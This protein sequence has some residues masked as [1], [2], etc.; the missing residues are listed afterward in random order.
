MAPLARARR[1]L[2]DEGTRA[3]LGLPLTPPL[4]GSGPLRRTGRR[5]AAGAARL[6][7]RSWRLIKPNL[8]FGNGL[9][10]TWTRA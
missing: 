7:F 9:Q 1:L 10:V 5:A 3:M 2:V 4:P 6:C 8:G